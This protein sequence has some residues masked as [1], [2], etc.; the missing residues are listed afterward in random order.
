[1]NDRVE[2]FAAKR[3]TAIFPGG[4]VGQHL[5]ADLFGVAADRLRDERMLCEVFRQA[6][7]EADF[8]ILHEMT[9]KFPTGGEG[10]TGIFLLAESHAAFHSYPERHYLAA[11]IFSCGGNEPRDVLEA[12][13]ESLAPTHVETDIVVRGP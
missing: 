10:V 6:L 4:A 11:D 2:Q 5:L 7:N 13:I 3:S 1:M 8:T 9:H 12:V